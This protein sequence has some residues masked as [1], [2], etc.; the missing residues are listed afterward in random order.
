MLRLFLC[1]F[2]LRIVSAQVLF[3][4][5]LGQTIDALG[6]TQEHCD[7]VTRHASH[8]LSSNRTRTRE[9]RDAAMGLMRVRGPLTTSFID[10]VL[11]RIVRSLLRK[12]SEVSL[13]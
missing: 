13:P 9:W 4:T 7:L 1:T 8:A 12:E 6:L 3:A 10:R 5:L 2:A 11:A